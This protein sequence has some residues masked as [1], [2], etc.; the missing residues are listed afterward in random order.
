M[1]DNN[2]EV[3][4]IKE[5]NLDIIAPSTANFKNF[6]Q[7]GSKIAIIGKTGLGKTSIM[8]AL[9]YA[10][11][12]IFPVCMLTS[13]VERESPTFSKILP[14]I[15]IHDKYDEKQIEKFIQ[16][17]KLA[18][19]HLECPWAVMILDDCTDD[20]SIFRRPLQNGIY[21]RSRHWKIMAILSLQYAMDIPPAVRT[22]TDGVFILR[23]P[24][25]R[26]RKKL[27][28]NYA[29]IIP[30]FQLFCKIMDEITN[31][32]TALYIHNSSKSN[33]WT[34]CVFWYKAKPVPEGFKFGC[35]TFWKH[36]K[37]RY[38]TEYKDPVTI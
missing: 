13:T 30:D 3:L 9:L 29:S 38:N 28:E 2:V 17:Q 15:F 20:P 26:N 19:E 27:Y 14:E 25:L 37:Q 36:H 31:D 10:K 24:N 7:G 33:N 34:D 23:D 21:K 16:R 35:D 8:C 12:H 11:K 32:F 1:N 4:R 18:K 5:L 6:E 22:N